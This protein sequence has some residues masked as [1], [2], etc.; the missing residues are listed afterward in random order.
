[1][2]RTGEMPKKN[3]FEAYKGFEDEKRRAVSGQAADA[4]QKGG[5]LCSSSLL[6]ENEKLDAELNKRLL[7]ERI[8]QYTTE[9]QTE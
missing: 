9:K 8:A 6:E 5:K 2:K 4:Y 3:G 7:E 1:M